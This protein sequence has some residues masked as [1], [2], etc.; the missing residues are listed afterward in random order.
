MRDLA[1]LEVPDETSHGDIE[2]ALG[3]GRKRASPPIHSPVVGL[4]GFERR[5]E[6]LVEGT[7]SKAFRS[8]LQPVEIGKK[9]ARALDTGRAV[10]VRGGMVAPNDIAVFLSEADRE[11]FQSYADVL[12]R[13]LA[14][15]ARVHARDEGYHFIGPVVVEL[16]ADEKLGI[17]DCDIEAQI[18]EGKGGRV[19]SLVLADG[20]RI[21]LGDE[22]AVIGRLPENAVTI[23]DP[24]ASRRHAEVRPTADGFV[25]VDLGSMNGVTVNGVPVRE[26]ELVDGDEIGIGTTTI[27]FEAS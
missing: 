12:S 26:H 22:T 15:A 8:G 14:E 1:R 19:G 24:R 9:I 10:G 23:T 6:R 27:R 5:L 7:F 17:G 3:E 2:K 20:G 18:A 16:I 4:Q 13:E 11:R 21:P 25:I